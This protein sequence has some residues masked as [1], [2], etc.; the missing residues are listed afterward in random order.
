LGNLC[1]SNR[2]GRI[3]SK[4]NYGYRGMNKRQLST[5]DTQF[6]RDML[7]DTVEYL[8]ARIVALE[9]LVSSKEQE[10]N[11][12]IQDLTNLKTTKQ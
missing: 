6:S 10:I 11:S 8:N 5:L 3:C 12:L 9:Q 2:Q 7:Y 4:L 1:Y